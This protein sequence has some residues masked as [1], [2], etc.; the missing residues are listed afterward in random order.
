[1]GERG[2]DGEDGGW[3]A[4]WVE[5]S[6]PE[7]SIAKESFIVQIP[8]FASTS[9]AYDVGDEDNDD[10]EEYLACFRFFLFFN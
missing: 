3:R 2:K 1:M 4:E 7:P 5:I 6:H 9:Y 10:H 8:N